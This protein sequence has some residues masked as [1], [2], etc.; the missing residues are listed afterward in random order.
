MEQVQ[1]S[2]TVKQTLDDKSEVTRQQYA[3]SATAKQTGWY[4]S[5]HEQLEGIGKVHTVIRLKQDEMILL[6]QGPLQSKQH[7]KAGTTDETTYASPYGQFSMIIETDHLQITWGEE[8]PA[9]VEIG[10][11]LWL[12]EQY[13]GHYL[14][15]L[16]MSW[17]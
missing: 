14:M 5:Y 13:I 17:S 8:R 7:F 9:Q 3:A 2:L 1:L 10:Y 12:N 15:K 4:L 16:E 11:R 6:R